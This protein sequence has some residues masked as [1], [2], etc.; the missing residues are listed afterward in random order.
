MVGIQI[1]QSP[2]RPVCLETQMDFPPTH[3]SALSIRPV[4]RRECV[5]EKVKSP[6]ESLICPGLQCL[7]SHLWARASSLIFPSLSVYHLLS[8]SSLS[9]AVCHS[10]SVL[11]SFSLTIRLY[12]TFFSHW[13]YFLNFIYLSLSLLSSCLSFALF[14][15]HLSVSFYL[16][17]SFFIFS[18]SLSLSLFLN[19]YFSLA[20]Y[21]LSLSLF[22]SLSLT[23][24]Y[25][26]PLSLSLSSRS[27][28]DY[29]T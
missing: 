19:L 9:L 4:E 8:L 12:V 24:G 18:S 28:H 17:L 20:L 25:T 16:P 10:L 22:L 29:L 6:M 27:H 2:S 23:L 11:C 5:M 7:I 15:S 1:R 3:T 26:L 13:L 21:S 14:F